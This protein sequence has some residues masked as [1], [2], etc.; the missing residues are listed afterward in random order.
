MIQSSSS[1]GST[2]HDLLHS[3]SHHQLWSR[4]R[5]FQTSGLLAG[6][7]ATG[8]PGGEG[9]ALAAH[10][11]SRAPNQLP[12]FS[13]ILK[14][15]FGIEIPGHL[16]IEVDPFTSAGQPLANPSLIWDFKGL[17]GLIEADGVSDPTQNSDGMARRWACDVRFMTGVFQNRAGRKQHGTFA[18]T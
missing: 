5:F 2:P 8:L 16:A 4:R 17:L 14:D 9:I 18:F 11:G 1:A 12:D 7:V 13:P 3:H 6:V 10:C 15:I